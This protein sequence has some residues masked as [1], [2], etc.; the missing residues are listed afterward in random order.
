M[1]ISPHSRAILVLVLASLGALAVVPTASATATGCV[2]LTVKKFGSGLWVDF[3]TF[4]EITVAFSSSS[5][6]EGVTFVAKIV[7]SLCTVAAEVESLA[8]GLQQK[9]S[10]A[11]GSLPPAPLLP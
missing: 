7:P 3:S 6:A 5:P 10:E 2:N 9:S 4:D 1:R 8:L 11:R